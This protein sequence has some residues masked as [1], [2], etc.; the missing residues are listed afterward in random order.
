MPVQTEMDVIRNQDEGKKNMCRARPKDNNSSESDGQYDCNPDRRSFQP[1]KI[2]P[3][4]NP[5]SSPAYRR[6][7]RPSSSPSPDLTK[8]KSPFSSLRTLQSRLDTVMSTR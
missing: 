8:A 1:D 2:D 5:S 4:T 3:T 6:E 7:L